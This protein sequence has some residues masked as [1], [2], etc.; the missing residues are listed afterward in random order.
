MTSEATYLRSDHRVVGNS[1][2]RNDCQLAGFHGAVQWTLRDAQDRVVAAGLSHRFGVD[3]R[4]PC[5]PKVVGFWPPKVTWVC[6][7]TVVRTGGWAESVDPSAASRATGLILQQYRAPG[8]WEEKLAA[9][10]RHVDL[11]VATGQSVSAF[12]AQ[13]KLLL[14]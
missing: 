6:P 1:V 14:G 13:A 2:L 9:F 12:M 8:S 10:K 4:G 5:V 7:P 3:G 11:A